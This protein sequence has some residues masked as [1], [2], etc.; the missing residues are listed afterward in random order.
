[1]SFFT[2]NDDNPV[3]V[4]NNSQVGFSETTDNDT[5]DGYSYEGSIGVEPVYFGD[6]GDFSG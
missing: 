1:M 4:D 2:G 5:F 3:D 6:N